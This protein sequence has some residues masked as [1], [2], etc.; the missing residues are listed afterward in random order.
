MITPGARPC[1]AAAAWGLLLL[2]SAAPAVAQSVDTSGLELFWSWA[3]RL[4]AGERLQEA[5][6]DLLFSHPGYA[7]TQAAGQRRSV[8]TH[9]MSSVFSPDGG[10]EAALRGL[11]DGDGRVELFERVCAHLEAVRLRREELQ[12]HFA[13]V[14]LGA[15]VD[16][17]RGQAAAYLPEEGL[18]ALPP[19]IVY[20][21]LFE[22][23]GFGRPDAIVV[24]GLTV[25]TRAEER[26]AAFLG[27]ELHH[28]Y[29]SALMGPLPDG[30]GR[31]LHVALERIVSEGVASMIDKA[32]HVRR[33]D[34]PPGYPEDFL[35]LV[36]EAPTRLARIDT[37]LAGAEVSDQGFAEAA[38]AVAANS[39][40]G[41]HLNGLYMAMTI[42]E[43]FGPPAVVS[44]QWH[45]M[46]FVSAYQEAVHALSDGR[47][48]FSLPTLRFLAAALASDPGS[49]TQTSGGTVTRSGSSATFTALVDGGGNT[50]TATSVGQAQVD[51]VIRFGSMARILDAAGEPR[52]AEDALKGSAS[53]ASSRPPRH[54]LR[55]LQHRTSGGALG[56]PDHRSLAGLLQGARPLAQPP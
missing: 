3:D 51:L 41:G 49:R 40:W 17:G 21:I 56:E 24:D 46:A 35:V 27:H 25:M 48:R 52:R 45:P 29:R 31:A 47:F 4:S 33:G 42:E 10:V 19:P 18:Q 1:L 39:P 37:A 15:L 7:V 2:V 13:A 43:A 28:A 14:D 38:R 34:V 11:P 26:N 54:P 50:V 55:R 30:Q 23:Q 12:S 53:G 16:Q 44:A 32:P 6:W 5:D 20:V 9:C 22:E 8:I 36:A